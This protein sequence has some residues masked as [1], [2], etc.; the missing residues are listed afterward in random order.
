MLSALCCMDFKAD[1]SM[2]SVST[3][4]VFFEDLLLPIMSLD[5]SLM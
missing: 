1:R 3:F 5:K 4:S 2:N